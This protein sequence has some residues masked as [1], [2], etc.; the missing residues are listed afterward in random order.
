MLLTQ[1][2]DLPVVKPVVW[3]VFCDQLSFLCS[4]YVTEYVMVQIFAGC[5]LNRNETG[6]VYT[7]FGIGN[8]AYLSS[9]A[10]FGQ[11]FEK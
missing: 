4:M 11:E 9:F 6:S 7:Y 2:S 8:E 5:V 1:I 10:A 3:F